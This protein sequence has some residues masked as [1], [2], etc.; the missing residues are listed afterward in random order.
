L[1]RPKNFKLLATEASF[2]Q[3]IPNKD[4][5]VTLRVV[6]PHHKSRQKLI[7]V[8]SPTTNL[9]KLEKEYQPFL[10]LFQTPTPKAPAGSREHHPP[11]MLLY[12]D[13]TTQLSQTHN[14]TTI[15]L[16]GHD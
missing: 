9:M 5:K 14:A 1:E 4:G 8:S 3:A 15:Y 13:S 11:H 12:L 7:L 6:S 10:M 16:A 2:T